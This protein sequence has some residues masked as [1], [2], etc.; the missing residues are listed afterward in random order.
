MALPTPEAALV[1][2]NVDIVG[3][4][5]FERAEASVDASLRDSRIAAFALT[6]DLAMRASWGERPSFVLA[7]GGFHPRFQPPPDFPG[8]SG[9]PCRCSAAT[10][11]G[12]AWS[13]TWR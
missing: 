12:C 6:G 11:R 10:T 1:V 7:A 3:T 4:V 5:D 2:V 13:R 8:S 9:S